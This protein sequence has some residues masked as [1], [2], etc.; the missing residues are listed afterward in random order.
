MYLPKAVAAMANAIGAHLEAVADVRRD[1]GELA[2]R[3]ARRLEVRT[4]SAPVTRPSAWTSAAG[5]FA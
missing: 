5:T 4:N 1:F 3:I 2:A